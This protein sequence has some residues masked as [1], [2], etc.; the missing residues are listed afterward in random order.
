MLAFDLARVEDMERFLRSRASRSAYVSMFPVIK[1]A[2]AAKKAEEIEEA[3]F[4]QMLAGQLATA[5]GVSVPDA[6]SAVGEL[7]DW[8]K[9]TNRYHRPLVGDE[10]AQARAVKAIVAEHARRSAT[11]PRT[12]DA[13]TVAELSALVGVLLVARKPNGDYVALLAEDERDI[14]VTE[15]TVSPSGR[16]T[17]AHWRLPGARPNRWRTIF[18]APRWAK[19]DRGATLADHLTG[20][21]LERLL[22]QCLAEHKG[23]PDVLVVTYKEKEPKGSLSRS[24]RLAV[25]TMKDEG[26]WDDSHLLTGS[27]TEPT[28][29]ERSFLWRRTTGQRVVVD[30]KDSKGYGRTYNLR[31]AEEPWGRDPVIYRNEA[32][33]V[34]LSAARRR[35]SEAERRRSEMQEKVGTAL[36]AVEAGWV[37]K[38]TEVAY[39]RFL[40]DYADLDLW[41]GHLKTLRIS[42]PHRHNYGYSHFDDG[43]T[44]LLTRFVEDGVDLSGKTVADAV[45]L[46]TERYGDKFEVP[47]DISDLPLSAD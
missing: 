16:R 45:S 33:L 43:L 46:G 31:G 23:D 47:E 27:R 1:A 28:V 37:A 19:W 17:E 29:T 42:Y 2:I 3:P 44:K 41:E 20:P 8:W 40:E 24:R 26:K 30:R 13:A 21:E 39:Q 9:F 25:W 35:W 14:F 18:E 15:V 5:N 34:L 10:A 36:K 6:V 4:R 32:G 11:L 7:V 38:A 12:D 22:D